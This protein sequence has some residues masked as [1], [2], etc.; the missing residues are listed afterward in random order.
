M[1]QGSKFYKNDLDALNIIPNE[2][3]NKP[4]RS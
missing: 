3:Y 2:L 4:P 1:N